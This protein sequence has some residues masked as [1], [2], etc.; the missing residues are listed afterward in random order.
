MSED[1][2][3]IWHKLKKSEDRRRKKKHEKQRCVVEGSLNWWDL[4]LFVFV[5]CRPS[6]SHH[7]VNDG[8][9]AGPSSGSLTV[10]I[11]LPSSAKTEALKS[12]SSSDGSQLPPNSGSDTGRMSSPPGPVMKAGRNV[13]LLDFSDLDLSSLLLYREKENT[14]P[15]RTRTYDCEAFQKIRRT[16]P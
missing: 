5:S 14:R 6:K 12:V 7:N 9:R 16:P 3:I 4:Y 15:R 10:R 8:E 13:A 1:E 2:K 11:K